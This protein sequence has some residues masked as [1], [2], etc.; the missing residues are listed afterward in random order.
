MD[1]VE[2]PTGPLAVARVGLRTGGTAF[3]IS[4]RLA[5]TAF[6]VVGDRATGTVKHPDLQ[7]VFSGGSVAATV[8]A[9]SDPVGDAALLHLD[10]ALPSGAVPIVLTN[11]VR[12]GLWFS[13]GFPVDDPTAAGTTVR[14]C[15]LPGKSS[16]S[17]WRCLELGLVV[18]PSCACLVASSPDAPGAVEGPARG[19]R[20]QP[21]RFGYRDADQAH[22]AGRLLA[23]PNGELAGV[24]PVF[25]L[26]S[27]SGAGLRCGGAQ[28]G[29][30]PGYRRGGGAGGPDGER[31]EGAH[32]QHRG[33]GGRGAAGGA[34][35][36]SRPAP[37]FSLVGPPPT[38]PP[39]STPSLGR[40]RS[41]APARRRT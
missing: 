3:A 19:C 14:V 32:G 5:L 40:D 9:R 8:D 30:C 41:N 27:G 12:R 26:V 24:A 39:P 11:E 18:V 31:P 29:R 38:P 23:P 22:V 34:G 35:G 20:E 2:Q 28:T 10:E 15:D 21:A 33:G 1:A 6:H 25:G 37:P 17:C 16:G 36:R 13:R 7:L 4:D